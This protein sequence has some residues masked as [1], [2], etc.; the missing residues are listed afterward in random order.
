MIK[1]VMIR[2]LATEGN[3][4]KKY[5]GRTDE[6]VCEIGR[7]AMYAYT[8]P[9]VEAVYTSPLTRCRETCELLY[10]HLTPVVFPEF[11]ECD[12]GD[13]E[14]KNYKELS[15]LPYYQT[16]IDSG[17][18]LPFPNGETVEGFK[19]RCLAGFDRAIT[20]AQ[21]RDLPS[22]GMILHGGT[23][24]SILDVLSYPHRDYYS[25]QVDNGMGYTMTYQKGR[26]MHLCSI[27]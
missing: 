12:F 17:G 18:T 22:I 5:I 14:N 8:Y 20:D 10:P 11:S 21:A 1:I 2:H 15:D 4:T 25:W 3:L 19:E 16:W 24:M 26:L 7:Q 27:Q 6:S 9:Q 23:I 13:F